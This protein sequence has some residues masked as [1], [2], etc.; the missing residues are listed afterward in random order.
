MNPLLYVSGVRNWYPE[1]QLVQIFSMFHKEVT[2]VYVSG[3]GYAFVNMANAEDARKCLRPDEIIQLVCAQPA[4]LR[5]R[6][7]TSDDEDRYENCSRGQD[8]QF[9][10][11]LRYFIKELWTLQMIHH[12]SNVPIGQGGMEIRGSPGIFHGGL[13][14]ILQEMHDFRLEVGGWLALRQNLDLNSVMGTVIKDLRKKLV[15]HYRNLNDSS[16]SS[17]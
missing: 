14:S 15:K 9:A 7:A 4:N 16:D 2:D 6:I 13:D 8:Y 11:K 5:V 1:Q 10:K 12:L 17:D 3:K